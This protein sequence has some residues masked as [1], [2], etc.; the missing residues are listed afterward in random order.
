MLQIVQ[1]SYEREDRCF[2]GALNISTSVSF[3]DVLA[4]LREDIGPVVHVDIVILNAKGDVEPG[5]HFYEDEVENDP[6]Q[7]EMT[8][9]GVS[10]EQPV[11]KLTI[12]NQNRVIM[13]MTQFS[14][15]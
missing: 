7:A 9:I 11:L 3:D 14:W 6:T 2:V 15:S 8:F 13:P 1:Y 4:I 10:N 12:S 5:Q